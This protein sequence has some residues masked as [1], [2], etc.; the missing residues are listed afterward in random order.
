[1]VKATIGDKEIDAPDNLLYSDKHQWINDEGKMGITDFA[2]KQLQEIITVDLNADE[3]VGKEFNAGD[4]FEDIAVESQKSVADIYC[5]VTGKIIEAN[6]ALEDEPEKINEDPYGEG[7]LF[8]LEVKSKEGLMD[9]N[10][11]IEFLKSL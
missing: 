4:L 11:Y 3:M 2:A 10:K 1:M 5:P 7:W 6:T 8:K 9:A